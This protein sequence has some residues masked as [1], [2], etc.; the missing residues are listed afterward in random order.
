MS[1]K[2]PDHDDNAP[3][4]D[5]T[6]DEPRGGEPDAP[7]GSFVSD[8]VRR[9]ADRFRRGGRVDRPSSQRPSR[10]R[11]SQDK[12]PERQAARRVSR[13]MAEPVTDHGRDD[14][15][16]ALPPWLV[17]FV[18]RAGGRDRALVAVGILGV[19]LIALIW[20]LAAILG[21][22]DGGSDIGTTPT[23]AI[24]VIATSEV[25]APAAGD[26]GEGTPF[27]V[28]EDGGSETDGTSTDVPAA[29]TD[30]P[31]SGS[32]NTLDRDN[33]ATP[34][35][36]AKRP[37]ASCEDACLIRLDADDG[38]ETV[39]AD[40]GTRAS[41]TGTDWLWAVAEPDAARQISSKITT[42][43]VQQSGNTLNLYMVVLPTP[44]SDATAASQLGEEVDSAGVYRLVEAP[45]V[46][47]N[48]LAVVD[49]GLTVEKVA[50]AP[51]ESA[52]RPQTRTPLDDVG[53][54]SLAQEVDTERIGDIVVNLQATSSNDGSGVG[55]RYYTTPGNQIAADSLFGTLESFGLNVWYEDFISPEGLLLVNVI[56]ELQGVDNS[57][58]YGVLAHFDSISDNPEVAAPGADDNST[59]IAGSLEIARI[60]AAHELKF[61]FRVVFV[62]GEEV[63]I[64]GS[65][66]FA[67]E[68]VASDVPWEGIFNL[69]SIGS[70]R[71]GYQI[72]LNAT[73]ESV[74]MEDLIARVNSE[75]GIGESLYI[76]QTEEIVADDN[77]LRNQGLE[78]VMVARELYGWSPLHHTTNDLVENMSLAHAQSATVLILLSIATLLG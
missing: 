39:L 24:Q 44:E 53:L 50:P 78:S 23:D 3:D 41:F 5:T 33:I 9:S 27:V 32:D 25:D 59:G 34:T 73:G 47:A 66:T 15:R 10:T 71:N 11:S 18:D 22:E 63:G 6:G 77:M 20:L 75:Q 76:L 62:N 52:S 70:P 13:S 55:T 64:L 1:S 12:P 58:M 17:A 35:P 43:V 31:G 37:I 68:A 36:V 69:D 48:V 29:G 8:S 57:R 42:K 38:A 19:A 26:G 21:G 49:A 72:V 14:E 67:R 51:P 28:D 65:D 46:P 16:N 45:T 74:W 56:G 7:F 61:G 2:P 60:F 40:N 54:E 4:H 30:Q